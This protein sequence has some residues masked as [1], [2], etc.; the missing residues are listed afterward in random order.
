MLILMSLLAPW[1]GKTDLLMQARKQRT[2]A[3]LCRLLKQKRQRD[4]G[5]TGPRCKDIQDYY[6]TGSNYLS[7]EIGVK[8]GEPSGG[9]GQ[10]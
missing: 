10:T 8:T 6:I 4:A 7:R 2:K 3:K 5:A 1:L 9:D